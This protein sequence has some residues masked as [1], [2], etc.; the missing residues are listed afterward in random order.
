MDKIQGIGEFISGLAVAGLG[1][2]LL[3]WG[4]VQS[5]RSDIANIREDV[6]YVRER[7]DT[8]IDRELDHE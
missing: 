8:L 2:A 3:L 6:Q 5:N 7:L 4:T 1:G